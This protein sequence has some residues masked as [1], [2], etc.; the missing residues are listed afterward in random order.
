MR[1]FSFNALAECL[2]I[3]C[4]RGYVTLLPDYCKKGLANEF[5]RQ[6]ISSRAKRSR[7]HQ[8]NLIVQLHL[9]VTFRHQF[10]NSAA[11]G[12][13]FIMSWIT[14]SRG[15]PYFRDNSPT[16][17]TFLSVSNLAKTAA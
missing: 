15:F 17:N 9:V 1:R 3:E 16:T 7:T 10:N 14:F 8:V 4:V 12:S 13:R 5:L 11:A 6:L 2:S